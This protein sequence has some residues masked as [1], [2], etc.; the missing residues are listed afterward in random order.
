I[1]APEGPRGSLT[2]RTSPSRTLKLRDGSPVPSSRNSLKLPVPGVSEAATPSR[3]RLRDARAQSS[4]IGPARTLTVDGPKT[5]HRGRFSA[6][7]RERRLYPP[8]PTPPRSASGD[9]DAGGRGGGPG[10]TRL[11]GGRRPRGL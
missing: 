6:R 5:R 3:G 9:R 4:P 7:Q 2:K 1:G 11:S 8:A 10:C